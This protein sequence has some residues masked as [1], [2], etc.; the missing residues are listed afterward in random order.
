MKRPAFVLC[1]LVAAACGGSPTPAPE[2]QAPESGTTKAWGAM[3]ADEKGAFMASDVL[4]KMGELFKPENPGFGCASCHGA[5]MQE[6]GFKMP[7]TLAP[8]DPE[9]MPFG[10]A[11][12]KIAKAAAWMKSDV[13]PRMAGL[14]G[15]PP[16]DPATKQGFGCFGCH[17]M[18]KGQ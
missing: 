6:V 7:N 10:A 16:Y 2:S 17:A 1:A 5:N 13:T 12:E 11:D 3:A 4:P 15:E 8:L 14:L 9:N 18:K